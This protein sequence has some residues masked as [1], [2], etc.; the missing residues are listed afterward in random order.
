[1]RID[2]RRFQTS[3]V[4]HAAALRVASQMPT[5]TL[6]SAALSYESKLK[7][8]SIEGQQN[9]EQ[10]GHSLIAGVRF[11][12]LIV[13]GTGQVRRDPMAMLP[14]CGY[15]MG[16][17]FAHWLKI[18]AQARASALPKIYYVNW[19]RQDD[20]GKFLWPGYGENSRV[21]KWIFQR[22]QGKAEARATP[23]G[24]LPAEGAL[25]TSGLEI[26]D[27]DLRALTSVDR[28]V[29][30]EEA[31]KIPEFYQRFGERLP[32]AL[33]EELEQLKAR[34][35][36]VVVD[37]S[38]RGQGVG[39]ALVSA[40]IE[41]ARQHGAEVVE[42]GTDIHDV[43]HDPRQLGEDEADH[44]GAR[45]RLDPK[46]LLHGERVADA[47]HH[48]RAI[49]QPIGVGDHLVPG[50]ALRHFLEAAVEVADLHLGPGDH[51]PVEPDH[52]PERPVRRRVRGAEV[53]HLRLEVVLVLPALPR[54]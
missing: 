28:E 32:A 43:V 34:L 26:A 52:G 48:R 53:Q 54:P 18:G 46:H 3:A 12:V 19:F 23:I 22:L 10:A 38:V 17:Y 50:V 24:N 9:W 40:C 39:R 16:D 41:L 44:L 25:D 30:R 7:I 31:A 8:Y 21:L 14:F 29:W 49:V 15:H 47:V 5:P 33:W 1:L 42:V 37:A 4:C 27:E 13:D 35:D 6:P 20:T 11:D 45:R 51:F 2:L 36:E